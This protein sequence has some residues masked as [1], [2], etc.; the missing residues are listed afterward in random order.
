MKKLFPL[1][2]AIVA[3]LTLISCDDYERNNNNNVI[4]TRN[5]TIATLNPS[6]TRTV[7]TMPSAARFI[8][9]PF[10]NENAEFTIYE[11][12]MPDNSVMTY[13]HS[14]EALKMD[15]KLAPNGVDFV[16]TNG[17]NTS[18]VNYT[19]DTPINITA[20]LS[21]VIWSNLR[22]SNTSTQ[23]EFASGSRLTAFGS[24]LGFFTN[25]TITDSQNPEADAVN[26]YEPTT[27][28]VYIMLSGYT[29]AKIYLYE[30]AFDKTTEK[31]INL[32]IE[33]VAYSIDA[34]SGILSL[35]LDEAI[36]YQM[37][38]NV[39]GDPMPDF[40]I[41]DLQCIVHAGFVTPGLLSFTCGD[42]Y[43]FSAQLVEIV[44]PQEN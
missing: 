15:F 41:N 28:N 6:G 33:D 8:F 17:K 21:G 37:V 13:P 24:D 25:A 10:T 27:N 1:F 44:Q 34:A 3:V 11:I 38:N 18:Y 2:S 30:A 32:V 22:T 5:L 20:T 39:K 14:P 31:K 12:K 7:Y 36:P 9:D 26:I 29:T 16:F 23:I 43:D 35:S 19:A 4:Y 42:R 40:K